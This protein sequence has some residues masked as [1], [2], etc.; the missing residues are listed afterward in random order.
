MKKP[1]ARTAYG[2]EDICE[3]I[4]DIFSKAE[5]P[6]GERFKVVHILSN[7]VMVNIHGKTFIV[8]VSK[9]SNLN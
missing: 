1:K 8:N 4:S 9:K 6:E 2:E 7:V 5:S 3:I